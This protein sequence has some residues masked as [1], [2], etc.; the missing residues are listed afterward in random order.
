MRMNN[1]DLI[2]K[3]QNVLGQTDLVLGWSSNDTLGTAV[4]TRFYSP[5]DAEAAVFDDTCVHNLAVYLPRLKERSVGVVAKGCDIRSIVELIVEGEVKRDQ[6]KVIF[7]PCAGVIDPKKAAVHMSGASAKA[8]RTQG[9][10]TLTSCGPEMLMGKCHQCRDAE[11]VIWDEQ[12]ED[13]ETAALAE[14]VDDTRIVDGLADEYRQLGPEARRQFWKQEFSRC[15]RC[16]ACRE[17]CPLCYCSDVCA[18]QSFKPHW[19]GGEVE[20]AASQM[21]QFVRISHMAG[22]CTGCQECER[23]CPVGIPL[24]LLLE[25]QNRAVEELFG[26]LPGS[27]PEARPPLLSFDIKE[28]NWGVP[29]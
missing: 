22:R 7:V 14:A 23:A 2:A 6:V 29:K 27:D 28:D 9:P 20:S 13:T 18:M 5:A 21:A 12:V 17:S 4:P 3:I 19:A 15:I 24:M 11:P 16:Y 10:Q 25:E 1:P 26:F 8:A